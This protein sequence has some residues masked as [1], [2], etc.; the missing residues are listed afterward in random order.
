MTSQSTTHGG[1]AQQHQ[2]PGSD[3]TV[4]PNP[5]IGRPGSLGAAVGC[6]TLAATPGLEV[7]FHASPIG[8]GFSVDRVFRE[9]N[10]RLCEM[11]GYAREE[12]IGQSVRMLHP[13][14]AAYEA[15]GRAA[16]PQLAE[17]GVARVDAQMRRKDGTVRDVALCMSLVE[18]GDPARG[19]IATVLDITDYLRNQAELR[20]ARARLETALA[21]GEL[22]LYEG[23]LVTGD[24]DVDARFLLQLG[25]PPD[26]DITIERWLGMIHPDD[27]ERLRAAAA[28]TVAGRI[29]EYGTEYRI[30][31]ADGRWRWLLDRWQVYARDAGGEVQ[32]VVGVHLDITERKTAEAALAE[33]NRTLEARIAERT[34]E[35]QHQAAQL[36][37]LAR[38]LTRTEQRE[39]KRLA[40][41][42][43][44]HI[45]QLIVAA[46][47]QASQLARAAGT[48]P[49][50]TAAL[51]VGDTL[52]EALAASRSLT[53]ELSPPVLHESGLV[54][55]LNWLAGRMHERH[56]LS[57][58]VDA[59]RDA[60]PPGDELR[61]P[62]FECA[63]ELLLNVVKHAGV[64]VATLTLSRL[65]DGT[66]RLG[67]ADDGRGFEPDS[68]RD[69]Q[70]EAMSFG[71]FSIRERLANLGG[72][73]ELESVPDCG[74]RVAL[75]VPAAAE[76]LSPAAMPDAETATAAASANAAGQRP[77]AYRVLIVDD[78]QIV[79]QGLTG[80]LGAEPD[81]EVIGEAADGAQAVAL[82]TA[83][84]PDVVIMDINLGPGIDGIEATR[85]VLA[86]DPALRVIGLSMHADRD[87][88]DAMLA[89]GAAGYVT[90]GGPPEDLIEAIRAHSSD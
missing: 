69:L 15:V 32:R 80:L 73:M 74:T 27:R 29:S 56:G 11:S 10:H 90:K 76:A 30:R 17:A 66:T 65:P 14:G 58:R 4:E 38:Q 63:R 28:D 20:T 55:G 68:L 24:V 59:E 82:A 62:L 70:P 52:T 67:V 7:L 8:A 2:R 77:R 79:R 87:V 49:L 34:A 46:Q 36:R 42:L 9:V 60:E 35:V 23:D 53:V 54:A 47:M 37:A 64:G 12:L 86:T 51:D 57:V 25:L 48:E 33:L 31:H 3:P 61:F 72:R 6:G 85:R 13:S 88:A 81:I 44:D 45:Q 89:A 5:R 39:R 19:V 40:T 75:F 43:H 22:G 50:R 18:P 83:L 26:A 41:I 1:S 71:L 16:Y 84:R 21:A 78:H